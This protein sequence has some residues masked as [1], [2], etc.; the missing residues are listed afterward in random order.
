MGQLAVRLQPLHTL[1]E[2]ITQMERQIKALLT[3]VAV[4]S[5]CL[6]ITAVQA[7]EYSVMS[8]GQLDGYSGNA[9]WSMA[10]DGSVLVCASGT[11]D[12]WFIW[13]PKSEAARIPVPSDTNMMCGINSSG[14]AVGWHGDYTTGIIVDS[15]GSVRE[16]PN[17]PG[18][19]GSWGIAINDAGQVV[20]SSGNS[21]V[22][23]QPDGTPVMIAEC[24]PGLYA[25]AR[26]ISDNGLVLYSREAFAAGQFQDTT[27]YIWRPDGTSQELARFCGCDGIDDFGRAINNSGQVVGTAGGHAILW[28]PDGSIA[29][30]MG[31]GAA[32]DINNLGQIVGMLNGQAVMWNA[33]LSITYLTGV[34]ADTWAEAVSINDHGLIAGT[35]YNSETGRSSAVLWQPVP[36]PS[37]VLALLTGVV[38]MGALIRRRRV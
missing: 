5:A 33:D 29:A 11:V 24:V 31:A 17:Y 25:T 1:Q 9:A 26:A 23:W 21:A 13:N 35:V 28:N 3:T 34:S 38:G 4:L 32:F 6:L 27:S 8:L 36:E 10:T 19:G 12:G 37:S 15:S 22:L 2:M 16:L 30:D 18:Y 20:G 7:G 14:Q